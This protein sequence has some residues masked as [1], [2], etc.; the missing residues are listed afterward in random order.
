MDI[1]AGKTKS[2]KSSNILSLLQPEGETQ[3]FNFKTQ[4]YDQY[5]YWTFQ[6]QF[7][8]NYLK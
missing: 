5:K 6:I 7:L 1:D 8:L 3:M 2:D 4:D